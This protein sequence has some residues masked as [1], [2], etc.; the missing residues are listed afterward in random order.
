MREY[1]SSGSV[2]GVMSDHDLYSDSR[3]LCRPVGRAWG[4]GFAE[5]RERYTVDTRFYH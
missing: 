5:V 1:R 2:E 3:V 4:I